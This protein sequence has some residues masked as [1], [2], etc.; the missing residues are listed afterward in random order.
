MRIPLKLMSLTAALT[1]VPLIS[2]QSTKSAKKPSFSI[3]INAPED[4]VKA[5][6]SVPLDI[7]LTNTS[8]KD[9]SSGEILGGAELNYEIDVRGSKGELAPETSFGRKLHHKEPGFT[10]GGSVVAYYLKPGRTHETR[11]YLNRVYDLSQ[12]GK[13]TILVQR[14]DPD[15]NTIVKSNAIA[16]TVVP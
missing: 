10:L 6:S 5:D 11:S 4:V 15:S 3:A 16:I 8:D 14:R 12:P 2:A 13:Y 7:I 9:M 1:I